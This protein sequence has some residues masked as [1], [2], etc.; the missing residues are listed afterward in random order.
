MTKSITQP[1]IYYIYQTNYYSSGWQKQ[2][3]KQKRENSAAAA[4]AAISPD[5]HRESEHEIGKF[6]NEKRQVYGCLYH[7]RYFVFGIKIVDSQSDDCSQP[8]EL[9]DLFC[10]F[11]LNVSQFIQ[12]FHRFNFIVLSLRN[13]RCL[14]SEK[15]IIISFVFALIAVKPLFAQ[16][17]QKYAEFPRISLPPHI[18]NC[19]KIRST[20]IGILSRTSG[21]WRHTIGQ[22]VFSQNNVEPIKWCVKCVNVN[23]PHG[24]APTI[25]QME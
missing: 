6:M 24:T 10:I 19:A 8:N 13:L 2:T 17:D 4:V 22:L 15:N 23:R 7:V 3:N 20:S 21:Q 12:F 5:T 9:A 25:W 11:H 18:G 1:N 14:R 16:V